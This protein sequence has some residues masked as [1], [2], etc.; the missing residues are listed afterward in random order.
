M[1]ARPPTTLT[2]LTPYPIEK[3]CQIKPTKLEKTT[4]LDARKTVTACGSNNNLLA[5]LWEWLEL[6]DMPLPD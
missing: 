1:E 5:R 2:I 3:Q 4:D 6:Q